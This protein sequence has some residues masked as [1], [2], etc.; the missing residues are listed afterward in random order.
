MRTLQTRLAVMVDVFICRTTLLVLIIDH[1]HDLAVAEV[2]GYALPDI[3]KVF[4]ISERS[5][6]IVGNP[7]QRPTTF[8]SL[9]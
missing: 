2:C 5:L 9:L 4:G 7:M 6:S 8:L 3:C 1:E